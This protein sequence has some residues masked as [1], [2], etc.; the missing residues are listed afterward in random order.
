MSNDETTASDVTRRTV[1]AASSTAAVGLTAFT[2]TAA[3]HEVSTVAFCGCTQVT[4]YGALLLGRDGTESGLYSAVLYCDGD[5]VR[6]ELTGTQTRQNYDMDADDSIGSDD[7]C[8]IIAL[9]GQTYDAEENE[10]IRFTI[11]NTHCPSNCA[12]KGLADQA[13]LDA[14]DVGSCDDPDSILSGGSSDG[15]ER[16]PITVQCSGC[17]RDEPGSPGKGH[18]KGGGKGKD[19]GKSRGRE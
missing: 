14:A 18:G 1:I 9:E 12:A 15:I 5:V 13:A 19:R 11:C 3:A 8:Q 17:G 6:R 16:Q 2:G 10:T 7:D 4:V